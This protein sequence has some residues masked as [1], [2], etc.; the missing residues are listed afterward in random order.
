MRFKAFIKQIKF[1]F[2]VVFQ[3]RVLFL[4]FLQHPLFLSLLP[5]SYML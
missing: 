4:Y 2:S 3:L 5:L 1:S